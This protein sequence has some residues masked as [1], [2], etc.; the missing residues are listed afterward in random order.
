MLL[1]K[2]LVGKNAKSFFFPWF[3][4]GKNL[5]LNVNFVEF[6]KSQNIVSP[7]EMKTISSS[8]PLKSP[9]LCKFID[10]NRFWTKIGS[11]FQKNPANL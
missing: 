1:H 11:D 3:S 4:Q 2:N 6:P 7:G 9:G 5:F 10:T 8:F